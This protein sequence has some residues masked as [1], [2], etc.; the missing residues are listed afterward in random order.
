M[1]NNT[2]MMGPNAKNLFIGL[3]FLLLGVLFL[4]LIVPTEIA[5]MGEYSFGLTPDFFPKV[6]GWM[7]V[8]LSTVLIVQALRKDRNLPRTLPGDV[9]TRLKTADLRAIRNVSVVFLACLLYFFLLQVLPFVIVSPLYSVLLGLFLA[10]N[11]GT[12]TKKKI[13]LL[14]TTAITTTIIIFFAFEK[15]LQI[16]LP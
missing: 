3:V 15:L 6:I 9:Y 8:V 13:L 16:K 12:P 11:T 14:L 5:V 10:I 2:A 4:T 7:I 1:K